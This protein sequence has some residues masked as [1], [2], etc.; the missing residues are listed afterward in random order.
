MTAQMESREWIVARIVSITEHITEANNPESNPF[1]LGDDTKF[2][3]VEAENWRH[4]KHHPSKKRH[5][6]HDSGLASIPAESVVLG[7][8]QQQQRRSSFGTVGSSSSSNF[9]HS[10]TASLS[11]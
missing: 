11:K 9:V 1:G 3:L 7:H 6:Q 4:N 5:I 8:Q 2:Y 10:Y